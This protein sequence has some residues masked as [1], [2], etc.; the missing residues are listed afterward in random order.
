[1]LSLA[2]AFML[3]MVGFDLMGLLVLH[4]QK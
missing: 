3:V 1:M 2:I 4:M